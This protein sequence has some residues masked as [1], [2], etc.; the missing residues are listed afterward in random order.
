VLDQP[1]QK[2][3]LQQVVVVTDGEVTNTDA[4]IALTRKHA[5]HA[6]V[7]AFGIGAGSSQHFVKE[8][9][10]Q[11]G[12]CRIHLSRRAHRA[13][14]HAAVQPPPSPALTDVR[15]TGAPSSRQAPSI[16]PPVFSGGRL[17]LYAFVNE[18]RKHV[19][20]TRVDWH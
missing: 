15:R 9:H 5:D 12:R 2:E 13:E 17:L 20:P 16:V 1:R 8:W 14:G 7:F 6:R 11:D 4:V 3:R 19:A 10:G 18:I